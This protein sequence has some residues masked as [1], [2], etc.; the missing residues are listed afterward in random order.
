[1]SVNIWIVISVNISGMTGVVGVCHVNISA[2]RASHRSFLVSRFYRG[3]HRVFT[4]SEKRGLQIL[5]S[6]FFEFY[7]CQVFYVYNKS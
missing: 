5:A 2:A 6:K 4:R 3:Y 7:G 1:M